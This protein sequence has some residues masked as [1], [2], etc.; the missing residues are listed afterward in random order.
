MALDPKKIALIHVAKAQTGMGEDAYR[1]LLAGLGV[2]SSKELDGKGFD[3]LMRHFKSLGFKSRRRAD[4]RPPASKPRLLAK[5]DAIRAEL[6]LPTAYVDAMARHMFG[7]ASH[8]WLSADQLHRLVAA[9]T[10]HQRRKRAK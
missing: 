7:I 2:A 8:R 10:Y 1:D 5:C 9:L 3:A 6:G 4:K